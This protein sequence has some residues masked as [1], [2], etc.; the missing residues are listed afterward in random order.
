[1]QRQVEERTREV[2]LQK[3]ALEQQATDLHKLNGDLHQK[4]IEEQQA[5]QEAEK[6]NQAK[7]I[8]LATMSHEIRTPMNGILGMALLMSQTEM[9]E[10]QAE[11]ADT[12]ISCGDGL[13]TVIN[14][15]LD[16]YKI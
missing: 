1:L 2:I 12:I 3:Q 8:F 9:T 4:H 7:S 11:Y 14:D 16:F 10:E 5:R 13:L 15:I 6:A